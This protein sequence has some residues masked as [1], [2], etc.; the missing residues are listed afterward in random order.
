LDLEEH[1]LVEQIKKD[2]FT[3]AKVNL[4]VFTTIEGK[5]FSDFFCYIPEKECLKETLKKPTLLNLH[6]DLCVQN[7]DESSDEHV[8]TMFGDSGGILINLFCKLH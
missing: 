1:A 3:S 5:P 6:W 4:S 2:R 7:E 8:F